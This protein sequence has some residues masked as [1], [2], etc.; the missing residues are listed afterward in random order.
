M[1][2]ISNEVAI[3]SKVTYLGPSGWITG[4]FVKGIGHAGRVERPRNQTFEIEEEEPPT[5]GSSSSSSCS[6]SSCSCSCCCCS[7]SSSSASSSGEGGTG[8]GCRV[9]ARFHRPLPLGR[10]LRLS[11]DS[12]AGGSSAGAGTSLGWNDLIRLSICKELHISNRIS[13]D[14]ET[15]N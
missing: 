1:V 5:A 10:P 2:N 12:A 15:P 6:C 14:W 9:G 11:D 13:F 7:S 3:T 8:D 4:R